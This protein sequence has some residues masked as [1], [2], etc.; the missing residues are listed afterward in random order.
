MISNGVQTCGYDDTIKGA[1]LHEAHFTSSVSTKITIIILSLL[2]LY[3]MGMSS[4]YQNTEVTPAYT[5]V[6][7]C[8]CGFYRFVHVYQVKPNLQINRNDHFQF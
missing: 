3:N 6:M 1:H 8:V 5:I 7:N 4:H 2:L